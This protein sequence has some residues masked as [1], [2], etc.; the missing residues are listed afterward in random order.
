MNSYCRNLLK[1]SHN[2]G[3][4]QCIVG[5][6]LLVHNC[7]IS[8]VNKPFFSLRNNARHYVNMAGTFAKAINIKLKRVLYTRKDRFMDK[9]KIEVK[10]KF[11]HPAQVKFHS[12]LLFL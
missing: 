3:D 9:T 6:G 5:I 8:R 10:R 12:Y 1:I 2:L 4:T 11:V 7:L